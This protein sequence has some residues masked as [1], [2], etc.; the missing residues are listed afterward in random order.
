[1]QCESLDNLH[2]SSPIIGLLERGRV[3]LPKFIRFVRIHVNYLVI[4]DSVNPNHFPIQ[5]KSQV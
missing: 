4:I 2:E 1:M 5:S 3:S